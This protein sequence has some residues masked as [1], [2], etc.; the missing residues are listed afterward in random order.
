M[1]LFNLGRSR[2][3]RRSVE[4]PFDEAIRSLLSNGVNANS[5]VGTVEQGLQ[6]I[7]VGAAVDLLASVVSE[8]PLIQYRGG[9]ADRR[10]MALSR[11][12]QDPG[13]DGY[14]LEDWLYGAMV[15]I[16]LRG[17]LYGEVVEGDLN[18]QLGTV[19]LFHPD[20]VT[21]TVTDGSVRWRVRG[22]EFDRQML[23]V[24]AYSTPGCV[25]G[26]SVIAQHADSLGVSLAANRYGLQWFRDG[27]HPSGILSNTEVDLAKE[28]VRQTAKDRFMAA[29]R[30]NR[31]PIILGKGWEWK[32]IQ[33]AANESQFLETQGYSSAECA[34]LFGPGVPEVLG[35]DTGGSMTYA[36]VVDRD[37]ALLKYSANRWL[38]R[39]ER[40]LSRFLPNPQY[41]EF[42]RDA[43]L[44]TN[45]IQRWQANKL[46]LDTGAKFINEVRAKDK[47][48]PVPWGDEPLALQLKTAP[49]PAPE[50]TDEDEGE[51]PPEQE[52]NT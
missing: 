32:A 17:N 52:D 2:P 7:A 50:P 24:R 30:G 16:L 11:T 41:V 40:L 51:T 45:A 39:F 37:L 28:S 27:A 10:E 23:H 14:G 48:P 33:V 13:G 31:E 9:G 6:V 21:A 38:R 26:R 19:P 22:Q 29:V 43:F 42:D 49:A 1:G 3:E 36:N 46:A 20:Q 8:L 25:L 15:S 4:L 35:Y 18:R 5:G 12:L 47:L 44:E 34:R